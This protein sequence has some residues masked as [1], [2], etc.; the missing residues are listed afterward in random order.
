M[1]DIYFLQATV[2]GTQKNNNNNFFFSK[3]IL[4]IKFGLTV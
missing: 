1:I 4:L 2:I 3:K